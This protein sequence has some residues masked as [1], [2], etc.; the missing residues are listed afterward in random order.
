[1]LKKLNIYEILIIVSVITHHISFQRITTEV[2][3]KTSRCKPISSKNYQ[4]PER[5]FINL[6]EFLQF[7]SGVLSTT[8]KSSTI[9]T[10]NSQ[11]L[12]SENEPI[13]PIT[14]CVFFASQ[15][16]LK[17][18]GAG[19]TIDCQAS[20]NIANESYRYFGLASFSNDYHSSVD[21]YDITG[22]KETTTTPV[23][24]NKFRIIPKNPDKIGWTSGKLEN[25]Q[26][27]TL[28]LNGKEIG[29]MVE[30]STCFE[31]MVIYMN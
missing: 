8:K 1:M 22:A 21:Y 23:F 16:I 11:K 20:Q 12:D 18:H 30:Q 4:P 6:E 3:E 28:Y 7:K 9:T 25:G 14:E 13:L 27:L 26:Y 10:I 2:L 31:K 15:G 17:C 5:C 24:S 19:I 29:I